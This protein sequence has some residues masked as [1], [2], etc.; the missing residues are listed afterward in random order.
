[1]GLSVAP[2]LGGSLVA[3]LGRP[4]VR[5]KRCGSIPHTLAESDASIQALWN[6]LD[7]LRIAERGPAVFPLTVPVTEWWS[8]N[9][10][11]GLPFTWRDQSMRLWKPARV[12]SLDRRSG[13][14]LLVVADRPADQRAPLQYH[15]LELS[16]DEVE[17][18]AHGFTWADLEE[19]RFLELAYYGAENTLR[20]GLHRV[21]EYRDPQLIPLVPP[22]DRWY[23]R[24]VDAAWDS[25]R[26]LV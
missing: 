10:H 19:G 12:E 11:T 14:L 16:R 18:A 9:G 20:I 4:R 5:R 15:D 17:H 6:L 24:A 23:R 25:T 22:P 2:P 26:E 3:P 13:G 1:M 7:A 8:A 21:T